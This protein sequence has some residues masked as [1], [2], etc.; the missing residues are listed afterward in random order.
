MTADLAG[1]ALPELPTETVFWALLAYATDP[2]T[3]RLPAHA[4]ELPGSMAPL[5][6]PVPQQ[7]RPLPGLRR[8]RQRGA[9]GLQGG[10]GRGGAAAVM[11]RKGAGGGNAADGAPLSVEEAVARFCDHLAS[12]MG[13][14]AHTV[15]AYREDMEAYLRWAQRAGVDPLAPTYRQLRRYLAELDQARYARTTIKRHLSSLRTF[16]RWACVT[17]LA[18]ADPASVLSAPK[19]DRRLPKVVSDGDVERLLAVYGPTDADGAPREQTAAQMTRRGAPGIPVLLRRPRLRGLR[20]LLSWVNFPERE[21]KVVR[22]ARQGAHRALEPPGR[23][24]HGPLF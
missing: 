10:P 9:C 20:L 14:S 4:R 23:R 13:A 6:P 5:S 12:E 11:G 18:P 8:P 21:V 16:F 17:G 22:Q 3:K 15:R 24:G 19:V 7:A 2:A 1:I